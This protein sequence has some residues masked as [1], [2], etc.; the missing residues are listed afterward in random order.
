M[1][2]TDNPTFFHENA[3]SCST[4]VNSLILM[5]RWG[6][7][8]QTWVS[9]Q[10]RQLVQAE[11]AE[12]ALLEDVSTPFSVGDRAMASVMERW[13]RF[14]LKFQTLKKKHCQVNKIMAKW[15]GRNQKQQEIPSQ[16]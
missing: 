3:Y 14:F 2:T 1:L 5:P 6:F 16:I 7:D 13:R 9:N 12:E 15:N 8:P 4:G 11:E 10:K